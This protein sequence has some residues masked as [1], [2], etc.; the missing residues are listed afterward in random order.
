MQQH[1]AK[2][3]RGGWP[4]RTSLN[5][6]SCN[7]TP[8]A[9]P[10]NGGYSST[11]D[12]EL[13]KHERKLLCKTQG[14]SPKAETVRST[15]V[16]ENCTATS[17][18]VVTPCQALT[19]NG[20]ALFRAGQSFFSCDRSFARTAGSHSLRASPGNGTIHVTWHRPLRRLSDKRASQVGAQR[21]ARPPAPSFAPD[22]GAVRRP[23]ASLRPGRAAQPQ[24]RP[25]AQRRRRGRDGS[26]GPSFPPPRGPNPAR[27][28]PASGL[29]SNGSL[30]PLPPSFLLPHRE[31]LRM[32][33]AAG[34]LG[35]AGVA[36]VTWSLLFPLCPLQG[37]GRRGLRAGRGRVAQSPVGGVDSRRGSCS[38]KGE[39]VGSAPAQRSGSACC[40]ARV[41]TRGITWTYVMSHIPRNMSHRYITYTY[42]YI[43]HSMGDHGFL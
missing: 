11:N 18:R 34:R 36:G 30:T 16:K 8:F 4:S 35:R 21:G 26:S 14:S 17:Y 12:L 2:L 29:A 3:N 39:D 32:R 1:R 9:L 37:R 19:C 20:P 27:P 22:L 24:T 28:R 7:A 10:Y 25:R 33:R 38:E 23:G 5:I 43:S 41:I 13:Q 40:S 42:L 31:V 6:S 15:P